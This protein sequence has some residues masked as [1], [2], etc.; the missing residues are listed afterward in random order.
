MA[1]LALRSK[2]LA[3]ISYAHEDENFARQ[4]ETEIEAFRPPDGRPDPDIFR[5]R[6]DF[7][8][9]EYH[10]SL[11]KHL[12]DSESLIVLCSPHA[13]KSE[14]VGDEIRK[15]AEHRGTGRIFPILLS[16]LA[17]NE[18]DDLKAFPPALLDV[19]GG[20]P[21]GAEYRGFGKSKDRVS[22]GRF[23]AE[24]YK[25]LGNLYDTSPSEIRAK[26]KQ[27]QVKALRQRSTVSMTV[28]ILLL[29]MLALALYQT[30][31]ADQ[32][33]ERATFAEQRA[34]LAESAAQTELAEVKRSGEPLSVAQ[35]PTAASEPATP[36]SVAT[37]I[38][39]GITPRV[40][41]QIS[42][43]SQISMANKLRDALKAMG[44][45]FVVPPYEQ[46]NVGPQD[47]P[48]L[49]YFRDSEQKEAESILAELRK[50]G[51]SNVVLKKV[52]GYE[53]S[54]KIRPGHF[55]LW[56]RLGSETGN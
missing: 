19:M 26:D 33:E 44:Q 48:E 38:Q 49:R 32:A 34:R 9:S 13:R 50:S 55:E 14:F 1:E 17:D 45:K 4:L 2:F 24:W 6:S 52:Q 7:T 36:P 3:F 39:A 23:E 21:L 37:S 46:L 42:N 27:R 54:T 18:A 20:I 53:N 43:K 35:P 8:G 15:F 51:L 5:D 30:Y 22:Q 41:F 16:G 40:Y 12:L 29:V 31:K 28:A 25:L 10:S 47:A 11:K 56:M